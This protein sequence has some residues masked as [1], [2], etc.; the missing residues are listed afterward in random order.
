MSLAS[1]LTLA[2]DNRLLAY[3]TLDEASLLRA[4]GRLDEAIEALNAD[5][6]RGELGGNVSIEL[7]RWTALYSLHKQRKEWEQALHCHEQPN[8]WPDR[9]KT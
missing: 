1:A 6:F 4:Q 2:G 5:H 3:A 9:K 8:N 7:D